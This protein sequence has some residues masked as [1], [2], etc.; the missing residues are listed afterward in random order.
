MPQDH[1]THL[2]AEELQLPHGSKWPIVAA[3]GLGALYVGV[4]VGP[5]GLYL[6]IVI[7]LAAI[8][9]VVHEDA[10]WWRN[11]VGTGSRNG[12]YGV[13]FFL[14]TE[15]M[16]FGALFANYFNG[17][18]AAALNPDVVWAPP[19]HIELPIVLTGINTI[20]LLASGATMHMA[21]TAIR[22]GKRNLLVVWCALTL[23]L[24]GVF[25]ALQVQ[26][27]LK[28]FEEGMTVSSGPFSSAFFALTGT[29]GAHV[30]GGLTLILVVLARAAK[31]NF[32]ERRHAAVEVTAIY[33]HFVDVVWVVLYAVVYLRFV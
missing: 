20:I 7:A 14:G 3:L 12:W 30:I 32:D 15:V 25:I 2:E 23:L 18:A 31:G 9:T 28:L 22:H 11:R 16:L 21:H 24:G 1:V 10:L 27:Y 26:E 13:L 29:H 6:A 8:F 5:P 4:I 19:G 33:W 17:Q